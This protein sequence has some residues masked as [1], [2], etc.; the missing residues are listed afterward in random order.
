MLDRGARACRRSGRRPQVSGVKRWQWLGLAGL[1]VGAAAFRST[2]NMALTTFAL[3][4]RE[5]VGLGAAV[6]GAIA[7]GAAV[8]TVATNLAVATR[9]PPR[10]SSL[11]AALGSLLLV[12]A[13]ILLGTSHQVGQL[14]AGAVLLGIGGGIVFPALTTAMGQVAREKR[15]RSLALFTLTLSGSLAVG[16]LVESGIL[17]ASSQNL[18]VPFL[19][20]TI[21]PCLGAAAILVLRGT[22]RYPPADNRE[23]ELP[24]LVEEGQALAVVA[25]AG[26]TASPRRRFLPR[27]GPLAEPGWRIAVTGELLYA[28]PF[29][30]ITVFGALLARS[31]FGVTPEQAQIGFTC[32]FATSLIARG[33]VAWRAPIRPKV[34]LLLGSAATTMLG[35][36]LL[37]TGHGFATLLLAMGILGLPHGV[38]FPIV[39]AQVAE[40]SPRAGL[41]RANASLLAVSN[42]MSIL[43]PALLGALIPATGYRGMALLLIAPVALFASLLWWQSRRATDAWRQSAARMG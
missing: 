6:I 35:L 34:P 14:A 42:S 36:L 19:V 32:F 9:V 11:A 24:A 39:L 13:L 15:E 29:A 38:T 16:P 37:G 20:F 8:A 7:A 1:L 27:G 31:A 22:G 21:L 43:V 23:P 5:Q 25:P 33:T 40:S 3:L 4:A 30:A 28:V 2:Q 10:A 41:A 26:S 18:R 17:G 12:P